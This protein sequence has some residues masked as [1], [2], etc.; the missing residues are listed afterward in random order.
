MGI[1]FNPEYILE[2]IPKLLKALP[3]TLVIVALSLAFGLLL[4]LLLTAARLGSSRILRL[5]ATWYISFIRGTPALVQL[6]LVFYGLPQVVKLIGIDINSWDKAIFA[7]ITFSLNGSAFL[8]EI[9]RSSYLAVDRGQQEAAFSVGMTSMQAF[10][11]IMLPQAFAVALPNLG[12]SAIS[13]IKE[14]SLAFTIGVV[15]IM[16]RAQIISIRS[17]GVN[18]LELYIA[19]ALIYWV[20]CYGI[21]KGVARLE[22]IFKKGQKGI[23]G[24]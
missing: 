23:A 3:F 6:F 16:G 11:R 17:N 8:S 12:N 15:D 22:K 4:A 14:T 20:L 9:M 13:L 10:R 21:E 18:Q 2:V 24:S 1:N 5:L 7:I 19:I